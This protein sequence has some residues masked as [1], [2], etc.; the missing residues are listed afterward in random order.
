MCEGCSTKIVVM[1][2]IYLLNGHRQVLRLP[3]RILSLHV[4]TIQDLAP[5]TLYTDWGLEGGVSNVWRNVQGSGGRGS[6]LMPPMQCREV[7]TCISASLFL[8]D[9]A[10]CL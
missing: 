9:D 3:Y 4:L 1:H 6:D 10:H 2:A 7:S 8:T 5:I